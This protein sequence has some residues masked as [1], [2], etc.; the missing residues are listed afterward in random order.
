MQYYVPQ[1]IESES[2]IIGPLTIKQFFLL[3]GPATFVVV[4][5]L[6]FKSFLVVF[7]LGG[8]FI[9]GGAAFAFFKFQGQDLPSVFSYGISYLIK[10]K[11]YIWVKKGQEQISLKEI[12]KVVEQKEKTMPVKKVGESKIKKLS[13][14][15]ET[16]PKS[17]EEKESNSEEELLVPEED[18]K[19]KIQE[20]KSLKDKLL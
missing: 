10:P 18:E 17:L 20:E 2:K 7:L 11:E 14:L 4:L 5:Y 1:F 12:E 9:G 3:A 13:W 8:I 16:K 15:L 6:I 19:Y